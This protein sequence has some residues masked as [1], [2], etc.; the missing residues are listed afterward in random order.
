MLAKKISDTVDFHGW[1]RSKFKK[2]ATTYSRLT[3]CFAFLIFKVLRLQMSVGFWMKS[4]S[5][6][7]LKADRK[8]TE[9]G[10]FDMS[11]RSLLC[12]ASDTAAKQHALQQ[13]SYQEGI[14]IFVLVLK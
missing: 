7:Y 12:S 6:S 10:A 13:L 4:Y 5:L 14:E 8:Q 3:F 1:D 9:K 11:Q 2:S